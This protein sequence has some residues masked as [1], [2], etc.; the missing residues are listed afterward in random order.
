MRA[1][2]CAI[3]ALAGILLPAPAL[4]TGGSVGTPV[5]VCVARV[6]PGDRPAAMFAR[7]GRFDCDSRQETLGPGDYWALSEPLDMR[8]RPENQRTVRMSS[9]WQQG[10][11][12]HILYAD[13]HIESHYADGP[14]I[15]R[16]IQLGAIIEHRLP[17]RDAPVVR[18]LWHVK[19]SANLRGIVVGARLAT[20]TQSTTANLT[21]GA[22]YAAF[23]G[24]CVALIVYNLALFAALRHRFQLAYCVMAGGLLLYAVSSSGTLAWLLPEIANNTRLRVNHLLL[25][26]SGAA[27]LVFARTFLE[28]RV[29]N[30][31]LGRA[32]TVA[33]L[34]LLGAG[35][36]F[37]WG[38]PYAIRLTDQI[39]LLCFLPFLALV[40]PVIVRARLVR[41]KY[42]WLYVAAWTAPIATAVGRVMYNLHLLEWNFWLD[43]S[44]ILA[45]AAEALISSVAIAYRMRVLSRERDEAMAGEVLAR[46]LA[47]TDPL[48]G[49]LNRRAFLERAIGR[50]GE[51]MLLIADLDHFKG[52]NE[53]LGHDGGDEVLRVFARTLR[54]CVPATALVARLGGEEFAIVA[55]AEAPVDPDA[56]L[57]RLRATR[58]P[59]DI[60]VT[61]SIGSCSG[62]LA[63]EVDW[64]TLYRGA[65]KALFEAK[66]AGRD[67]ARCAR[68]NAAVAA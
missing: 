41:S 42:V 52:V 66:S 50:E 48:T 15:T 14:G 60:A 36:L 53:T 38:A 67:R 24:L 22:V 62:P 63:S 12:L 58:M 3:V 31:W 61:A 35:L 37:F 8:S 56:V 33:T 6:A 9:L 40:P 11:D 34:L 39:F 13:G 16:L 26:F 1:L 28:A 65:D 32:T 21:M 68:E 2:I 64:K 19:G 29:F 10:L 51:Q 54:A 7:P 5:A 23:G 55:S 18:L 20:A 25:A 59:F 17:A 44:T 4:A 43:N 30:G 46:R 27:G 49:L 47:E 57:A 45:M